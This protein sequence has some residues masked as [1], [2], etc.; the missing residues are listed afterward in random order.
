MNALTQTAQTMSSREIAELTGKNHSH[1]KRDIEN[2]LQQLNY[3]DL[4]GSNITETT[5]IHRGNN[6]KEYNLPRRECEILVT[7]YDVV[8]RA[9]VIDRWMALE[10]ERRQQLSPA[11]M[12]LQSAQMMVRI[13]QE[14]EALKRAQEQQAEALSNLTHR[15]DNRG[16]DEGFLMITDAHRQYGT[17]VSLDTFKLIMV[18]YE[19]ESKPLMTEYGSATKQVSEEGVKEVMCEFEETLEHIRNNRYMHP[20]LGGRV[21]TY[22]S[23]S[24][25]D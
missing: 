5:Y 15:F 25:Y 13:E 2:M 3:P 22:V 10:Q 6:Y 19:V 9:A 12:F 24:M 1:V 20:R 17:C 4:E 18:A 16:C 21:F 11:E 23:T 7:G 14:Q 8:R